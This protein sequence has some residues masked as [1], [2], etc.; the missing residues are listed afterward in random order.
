MESGI[1]IYI[2]I[3]TCKCS[4]YFVTDAKIKRDVDGIV[5]NVVQ[6]LKLNIEKELKSGDKIISVCE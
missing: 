5:N 4:S 6:M 2:K 3:K 1:I